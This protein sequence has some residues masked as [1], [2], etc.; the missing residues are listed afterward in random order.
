M[1]G[2][3]LT[4]GTSATTGPTTHLHIFTYYTTI[5]KIT[6][7]RRHLPSSPY[8][9]L[10]NMGI[11]LGYPYCFS[12]GRGRFF[13]CRRMNSGTLVFNRCRPP[14]GH[15]APT[16]VSVFRSRE[17]T[18]ELSVTGVVLISLL[19]REITFRFYLDKRDFVANKKTKYE[20]Y[21]L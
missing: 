8:R 17:T 2:A 6:F 3:I 10:T 12:Y 4:S 11:C 13:G 15:F 7:L 16:F 19:A 9:L 14:Y 18:S 21:V 5:H 1:A 20:M